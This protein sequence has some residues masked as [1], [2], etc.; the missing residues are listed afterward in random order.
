MA[1]QF[2][3]S[4]GLARFKEKLVGLFDKKLTTKQDKGDYVTKKDLA[5][6]GIGL[7]FSNYGNPRTRDKSDPT[8]GLESILIAGVI[9]TVDTGERR[10]RDP[11]KP[12]FG[13]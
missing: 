3:D 11:N 13:L 6:F 9:D 10:T 1:R 7:E 8:Y 2:L 5:G 12:S 4:I